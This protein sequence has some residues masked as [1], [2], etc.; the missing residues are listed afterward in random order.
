[1]SNNEFNH[2]W[3]PQPKLTMAHKWSIIEA[4]QTWTIL[5]LSIWKK[6]KPQFWPCSRDLLVKISRK[7]SRNSLSGVLINCMAWTCNTG[8]PK[9]IEVSIWWQGSMF[10]QCEMLVQHLSTRLECSTYQCVPILRE[11]GHRQCEPINASILSSF[12]WHHLT[13]SM[14][15]KMCALQINDDRLPPCVVEF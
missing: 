6:K 2:S 15:A 7:K 8:A 3:G 4:Y 12:S 11:A 9:L 1:M 5:C 14:S 10:T 13:L